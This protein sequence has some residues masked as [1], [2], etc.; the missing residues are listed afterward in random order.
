VTGV[1]WFDLAKE[2]DWRLASSAAA[3][4]AATKS[5]RTW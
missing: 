3:Q 5:L 4:A 2:T 1:V